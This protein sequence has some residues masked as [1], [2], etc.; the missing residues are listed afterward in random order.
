MSI[1][2]LSSPED[3]REIQYLLEKEPHYGK[4]TLGKKIKHCTY[5]S[6]V[7]CSSVG[8]TG[9]VLADF[10]ILYGI[11]PIGTYSWQNGNICS[12]EIDEELFRR[13]YYTNIILGGKTIKEA[14][15]YLTDVI[16][17]RLTDQ[18]IEGIDIKLIF[19]NYP[20]LGELL[21]DRIL[22]AIKREQ[23]WDSIPKESR[24]NL[25]ISDL[26]KCRSKDVADRLCQLRMI[27]NELHSIDYWYKVPDR[28]LRNSEMWPYVPLDVRV[29][30]LFEI[31]LRREANEEDL[32]EFAEHL[33][34]DRYQ[35]YREK[36]PNDLLYDTVLFSSLPP[37]SQFDYLL[38]KLSLKLE[39][40]ERAGIIRRIVD[41][42]TAPDCDDYWKRIPA[43]LATEPQIWPLTPVKLKVT[44]LL[45]R[46]TNTVSLEEEKGQRDE[47]A[48]V[49]RMPEALSLWDQI[50]KALYKY[51]EFYGILPADF[52]FDYLL[53]LINSTSSAETRESRIRELLDILV[54]PECRFL[55]WRVPDQLILDTR[56]LKYAPYNIRLRL[57]KPIAQELLTYPTKSLIGAIDWSDDDL[58]LA[59]QWMN[60]PIAKKEEPADQIKKTLERGLTI[61]K[62]DE[63][64]RVLS[65]RA[66]ELA[67]K[68][69]F[70][71]L[72]YQP[73][74]V[75]ILQLNDPSDQRWKW[76]DIK[77]GDLAIDVKNARASKHNNKVFA[78]QCVNKFKEIWETGKNREVKIAGVF[79][80][81]R[82]LADLMNQ[83]KWARDRN[84][85]VLGLASY[86]KLE[87]LTK[88]Y[89]IP[90]KFE[91]S[92]HRDY[93]ENKSFLPPWV[94]DYPP[95]AYRKRVEA[96]AKLQKIKQPIY[97]LAQEAGFTPLPFIFLLENPPI[98]DL[99]IPGWQLS[100]AREFCSLSVEDRLSLPQIY[101]TVLRHF[102]LIATGEQQETIGYE[103][104]QYKAILFPSQ[105]DKQY[106]LFVYDPLETVNSLIDTLQLL[107]INEHGF[108]RNFKIF[109]LSQLNVFRGKMGEKDS[110]KTL[111]AYC[112]KCRYTPLIFGRHES[113]E[114]GKLRCPDPKCDY[115]DKDCE[116]YK[117]RHAAS[118]AGDNKLSQ[119]ENMRAKTS[120]SIS[121]EPEYVPADDW[122]FYLPKD[123]SNG[124]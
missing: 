39:F 94:Y 95:V 99:K 62:L 32:Q 47:L 92:F 98:D 71:D 72:G 17:R 14:I 118:Q 121:D 101:L 40:S 84:I 88:R 67:A 6:G 103:P 20:G 5:G 61:E 68:R 100:L 77:C 83:N 86:S 42:L 31:I 41:F 82:K 52:K 51:P 35:H 104:A 106:P 26:K 123:D 10:G 93:L 43:G 58:R 69:Y 30:R 74:D 75:S 11:R 80:Q 24:F 44:I 3:L 97:E 91:L 120:S 13:I 23:L 38:S 122:S 21:P 16:D 27:L 66:A 45:A 112:G 50:P 85:Q 18:Q 102:I 7:I 9:Y 111:I 33:K 124:F 48:A 53:S 4:F 90:G 89:R 46:I 56:L 108:I 110:W 34:V 12:L 28:F 2:T 105:S 1:I 76:F 59:V 116:H 87:R 109:Q 96:I 113:C 79:S 63:L 70:S 49:M 78:E 25:L 81:H 22:D 65:A 115:C 8:T 57:F 37:S 114:C 64:N 60:P 15:E 36:L 55:W 119:V 107:W 117:E 54:L 19:A 73:E 29:A